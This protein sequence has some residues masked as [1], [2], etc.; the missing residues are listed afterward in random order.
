M[1]TNTKRPSL[2]MMLIFRRQI[3]L[4]LVLVARS[5]THKEKVPRRDE[6]R[7][8]APQ[9]KPRKSHFTPTSSV[10]EERLSPGD[11]DSAFLRVRGRFTSTLMGPQPPAFASQEYWENRFQRTTS[12]F[13]WLLPAT[14]LDEHIIEGLS[15]SGSPS[16]EILHIGCGTSLLSFHLRNHVQS[17]AQVH[18]VDFSAHAVDWGRMNEEKIFASVKKEVP[19]PAAEHSTSVGSKEGSKGEAEDQSMKWSQVS[20]LSLNSVL[21]ACPTLDYSLVIDKSTC[22][23]IA[24]GE[25]VEV[26]FPFPLRKVQ[27]GASD[28]ATSESKRGTPPKTHL[29]HPINILALNLALVTRPKARWIALSYSADRFSFITSPHFSEDSLPIELWTNGFPLP[30]DYWTVLRKDAI[31]APL[32][33]DKSS[34]VVHRPT[35]S[36]WLYVLERTDLELNA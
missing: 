9:E 14:A 26:P 6:P 24:C 12:S 29:V 3:T 30:S 34:G 10:T 27:N 21:S 16:P 36:H 11:R 7:L 18:N 19:Y 32:P 22:D 20:L 1:A 2:W 28:L 4:M 5:G 35:I 15:I 13:D 31:E 23:A 33:S 8:Q 17:P 25:D